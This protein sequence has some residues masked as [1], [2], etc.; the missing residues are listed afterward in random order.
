MRIC[1]SNKYAHIIRFILKGTSI[2]ASFDSDFSYS[3]QSIVAMDAKFF[4]NPKL[5]FLILTIETKEALKE[6]YEQIL[7]I[8]QKIKN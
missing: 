6:T 3:E 4:F 7:R 8:S 5:D 2:R 1:C